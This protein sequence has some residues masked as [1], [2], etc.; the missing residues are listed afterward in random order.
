MEVYLGLFG[1][2]LLAAT[3]LPAIV[4]EWT[5]NDGTPAATG[6][7]LRSRTNVAEPDDVVLAHEGRLYVAAAEGGYWLAEYDLETMTRDML[8]HLRAK[9]GAAGVGE[10]S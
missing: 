6:R 8:K 10:R 5:S 4:L 1:V 9:L 2:S 3:V 7:L